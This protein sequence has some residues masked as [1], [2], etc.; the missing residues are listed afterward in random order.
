MIRAFVFET[1]RETL[2]RYGIVLRLQDRGLPSCA[3][4]LRF[5]VLAS[6]AYRPKP[7]WLGRS[8]GRA[9]TGHSPYSG[10]PPGAFAMLRLTH[11]E[12][13]RVGKLPRALLL[14]RP[15]PCRLGASIRAGDGLGNK[16]SI[17]ISGDVRRLLGSG[18][19]GQDRRYKIQRKLGHYV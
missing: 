9:S 3:A 1:R 10:S 4:P 18:Y 7:S 15:H 16:Y 17:H 13:V 5:A 12:P 8:P 2:R 6:L 11:G 14:P 19:K